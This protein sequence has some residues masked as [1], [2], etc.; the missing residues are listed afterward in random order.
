M[1]T[2]ATGVASNTETIAYVSPTVDTTYELRQTTV[3]TITITNNGQNSSMEIT[4]INN[5]PVAIQATATGT[6]NKNMV[7]YTRTTSQSVSANT[8]VV[9]DVLENTIGTGIS[10][11]TSTGQITLAT[12]KTYRLRGTVGT[13]VGS[14]ADSKVGYAWYNETTSAWIGEGAGWTSPGSGAYNTT[15]GGTAEAI[16]TTGSSTVVSFRIIYVSNVTSI[17]GNASDFGTPYGNPWIDIEEIT[18]SF[19]LNTLST[20]S[21]SGN[22]SVGGTLSVTG[23]ILGN[24]YSEPDN[25][26]A[27]WMWL[28]TWTTVQ[29]GECL[30][31]RHIG[32][33]GYSAV[34]LE[35]QVTELMFVTSNGISNITGTAGGNFYANGLATVNSRLGTGGSS[36]TY[37]APAKFR[38]VQVSTISY[39]I[40]VYYS[41]AYMRNSNYTV[42]IGPATSWLNSSTIQGSAPTGTY[43]DITP[44]TF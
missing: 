36:I 11:N 2:S 35:N 4:Q 8:V 27:T 24:V 22:V 31:M 13:I 28:G 43:L 7:K 6:L 9:C 14:T 40:Y 5:I 30:Y 18:S 10:V 19:A 32:H 25:A 37:Q 23:N 15:G 39:Q 1:T 38:I 29:N 26:S 41:A 12:G 20:M 17:G 16:I 42:Q 44:S 33:C 21:V 34:A 3:N